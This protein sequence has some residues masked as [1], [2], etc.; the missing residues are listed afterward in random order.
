MAWGPLVHEPVSSLR[1]GRVLFV[2]LAPPAADRPGRY[3]DVLGRDSRPAERAHFS[4]P[5]A[6]ARA[7]LTELERGAAAD[8]VVFGGAGDPLRHRGLGSILRTLRTRAH[9][10]TVVLTD[11]RLLADRDVR[12]EV[13]E[14]ALVVAWLPSVEDPAAGAS[15]AER[16]DRFERHVENL[17]SL[18]REHPVPIAVELP[19]VPGE[20]DSATSREAWRRAVA[21]IRPERI[22]VIPGLG[23]SA[24]ENL[25]DALE[26]VRGDLP[27]RAGAFLDDGTLVDRRDFDPAERT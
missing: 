14:A 17:A 16:R 3:R 13:S 11:G 6:A 27:P 12:R 24:A 19:V 20:S 5:E 26:R 7:V 2:E 9:V 22:L 25:A 8:A 18:A 10:A 23:A 1:F 4:A 21:R 15:A